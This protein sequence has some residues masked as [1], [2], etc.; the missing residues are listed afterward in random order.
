MSTVQR[1]K[2]SP[3]NAACAQGKSS[4]LV[5]DHPVSS[6]L[7]VFGIGLGAGVVVANLL[8]GPTRPRPTLARRTEQA[9]EQL[10]RQV[11]DA[12]GGVLPESLAKHVSG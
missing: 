2:A 6:V 11:L 9:A 10:G 8:S 7:I 3:R 5:C 12:I 1:K 4:Q